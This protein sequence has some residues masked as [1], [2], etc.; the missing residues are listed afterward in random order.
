M[1]I[2]DE[3]LKE[4]INHHLPFNTEVEAMAC[5]LRERRKADR[6]ITVSEG[7][8]ELNKHG[9]SKHVSVSDGTSCVESFLQETI[10]RFSDR[11]LRNPVTHWRPL[12][13]PPEVSNG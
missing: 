4:I 7:L 2:S 8:P 13:A 5:E 9:F 10:W 3:R 1:E 6:W 12:P 11:F